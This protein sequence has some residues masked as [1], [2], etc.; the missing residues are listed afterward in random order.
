MLAAN[1]A[2]PS[3]G[4]VILNR[5]MFLPKHQTGRKLG[6]QSK[7]FGGKGSDQGRSPKLPYLVSCKQTI[8]KA[9]G[10]LGPGGG[11]YQFGAESQISPLFWEPSLS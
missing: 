4:R 2:A 5:A 8:K 7:I 1:S 11:A 6:I 10:N 3:S 9:I